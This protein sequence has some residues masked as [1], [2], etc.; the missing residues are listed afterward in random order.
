MPAEQNPI[1]RE[2]VEM[3]CLEAR[4]SDRRKTI[5]PPLVEGDQE[6]VAQERLLVMTASGF[7]PCPR[8]IATIPIAQNDAATMRQRPKGSCNR[9]APMAAAI[10]TLVSRSAAIGAI[11]P[12]L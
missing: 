8:L 5:R 10:T 11:A 1:R 12:R 9:A 3:R 7:Y 2:R 6:N 4:M